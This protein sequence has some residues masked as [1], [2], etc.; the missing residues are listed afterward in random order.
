M[1]RRS[2][3]KYIAV[4]T[5]TMMIAI[6]KLPAKVLAASPKMNRPKKMIGQWQR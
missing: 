3:N 1:N 5:A 4:A 6:V 2:I